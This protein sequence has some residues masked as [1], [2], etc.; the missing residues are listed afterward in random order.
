MMYEDADNNLENVLLD[1]VNEMEEATIPDNVNVI[2]LI[3]R[4]RGYDASDGN[5]K[6]AKL[7][8]I[9]H[10][11][12]AKQINSPRLADPDFLGLTSD[13]VNG[14]EIDMGVS[15]TLSG[16]IDFCKKAFPADHY[17]LHLSDHGDGWKNQLGVSVELPGPVR[18]TCSDDSSGNSLSIS[19]DLPNA[20]EGKGLEAVTLD[21]CSLGTVEVAWALAPHT[22]YTALSV[23]TVPGTGWAYKETL[24]SWFDHM[25]AKNWVLTSVEEYKNY[26]AGQ[27]G[28][29]FTALDLSEMGEFVDAFD[30]FVAIMG[31]AAVEEIVPIRNKTYRPDRLTGMS[32]RDV[33]NFVRRV[34]AYVGHETVEKVLSS[35]EK[36]IL[37]YWYTSSLT[38]L[39]GLTIYA[40]GPGLLQ[41]GPYMKAYD[42][43]PFAKDTSWDEFVL[44]LL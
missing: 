29:G 5:W 37:Y 2:V 3:D 35:Y 26:Y 30:A 34:E 22:K 23:M 28:V 32:M 24:D 1:D 44:S 18:A 39:K 42:N 7:F 13:S 33:T 20:I 43:T 38:K 4:A 10:D 41:G 8:H 12:T 6:G 9:A 15:E 40:P 25:S 27:P 19:E 14:E 21:A 16:F 11:E 31:S 17:I 36:T